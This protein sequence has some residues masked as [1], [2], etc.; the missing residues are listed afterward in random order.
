MLPELRV[1]V[2]AQFD[3]QS[4]QD[5]FHF[6]FSDTQAFFS[7]VCGGEGAAGAAAFLR[8]KLNIVTFL[9]L[10]FHAESRLVGEAGSQKHCRSMREEREDLWTKGAMALKGNGPPLATRRLRLEKG[11]AL[12]LGCL[13]TRK[14]RD[15]G[16]QRG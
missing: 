1:F 3:G 10:F 2:V 12:M 6:T 5:I 13:A 14:D 11:E 4:V 15:F 8:P 16:A 7:W 9:D